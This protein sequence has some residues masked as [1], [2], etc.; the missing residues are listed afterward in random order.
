MGMAAALG[1][2]LIGGCGPAPYTIG[3]EEPTAVQASCT[4]HV[5]EEPTPA[6][7]EPEDRWIPDGLPRLNPFEQHGTWVGEYDCPQG[8]TRLAL[9]TIRARGQHV[10]AVFDFRHAPTEVSGKFL[11][12]GTFDEHTGDVSLEPVRWIVQPEGY[13]PVGMMGRV[14]LDGL[15]FAGR[16]AHPHCGAFRLSAAD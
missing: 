2:L 5:V 14:S 1:A 15:R 16:I 7:R 12:E 9:R 8:R 13:E 4:S 6:K 10:S 11:V 3:P